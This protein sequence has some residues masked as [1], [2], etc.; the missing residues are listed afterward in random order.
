MSAGDLEYVY[1]L[2]QNRR[3]SLPSNQIQVRRVCKRQCCLL[4]TSLL[5][6]VCM[7]G[8]L[9]ALSCR[10]IGVIFDPLHL[11]FLPLFIN[12][13]LSLFLCNSADSINAKIH[14]Y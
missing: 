14:F 1:Q 5:L 8:M 11:P 13:F 2:H 6:M 10:L 3:G 4:V 9:G 7:Q 12:P